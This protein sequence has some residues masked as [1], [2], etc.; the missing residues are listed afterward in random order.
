MFSIPLANTVYCYQTFSP[1]SLI[2]FSI[3]ANGTWV[4][5]FTAANCSVTECGYGNITYNQTCTNVTCGGTHVL[6]DGKAPGATRLFNVS[7]QKFPNAPST[8]CNSKFILRKF[9]ITPIFFICKIRT[10]LDSSLV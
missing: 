9:F 1:T 6:C 10:N 4:N 8:D 2:L 3:L 5:Q 7:C